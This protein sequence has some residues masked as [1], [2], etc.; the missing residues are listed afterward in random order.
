MTGWAE[1]RCAA[2]AERENEEREKDEREKEE[3]R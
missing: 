3:S 1:K 2:E